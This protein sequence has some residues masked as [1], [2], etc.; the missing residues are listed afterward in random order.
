M[1]RNPETLVK[2]AKDTTTEIAVEKATRS[3]VLWRSKY[4][5]AVSHAV[6][7]EKRLDVLFDIGPKPK[8]K[9]IKAKRSKRSRGVAVIAP[10]TDWHFEEKVFAARTN[11]KNEFNL[12]EAKRR[13]KQYYQKVLEMI[14]Q[15]D[16]V[17]PVLE[18]WHP[19]LGDLMS[20]YIHEELMET[21][22]LSPTEACYFLQ[23]LIAAGIDLW[24]KETDLPIFI[25]TCVGNHSR[26][27][28]KKRVKTS[29]ANNF[30]WLMFK[31]MADR[32]ADNPRVEWM[33]G[34]GYHN[35]QNIRGRKVRF[36][37]GDGL[38]YQGGVGG[39]TIPVNK[40]IAAWNQADPVDLDV[41][42][43]WHTFL[44]NYPDWVSCGALIG[45]SEY[46]VEIKAKFQHPTQT[47]IVLDELYGVTSVLP[48]FLTE[49][50]RSKKR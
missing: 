9:V 28:P 49:P 10:A 16:G 48:I 3:A 36:H 19:L 21:N 24:L 5:E 37:H 6:N 8:K 4:K 13:I 30:E 23:Q 15:Q 14:R 45:Y 27:T 18:L 40:S 35:V 33:V 25:P 34:E 1:K 41:F 43:H 2:D 26:T 44:W 47:F 31:M 32:Y 42:G 39:I 46:A 17:A 11:G 7:I 50:Q 29:C 20:G 38:R 12:V 22:E